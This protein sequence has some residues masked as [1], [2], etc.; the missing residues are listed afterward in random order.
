[1]S[2]T[3][4][5]FHA[6]GDFFA[7]S[8]DPQVEATGQAAASQVSSS[9]AGAGVALAQTV[10]VL[11]VAGAQ[12]ALDKLGPIGQA[13]SPLLPAVIESLIG[14]LLTKHPNPAAAVASPPV[15]NVV[16]AS[17]TQSSASGG[18]ADTISGSQA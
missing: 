8:G 9:L 1:M 2:W 15:Q 6:L 17:V 12:A 4:S 11:A 13:E 7:N 3:S 10:P 14:A 18:P 5:F 16:N